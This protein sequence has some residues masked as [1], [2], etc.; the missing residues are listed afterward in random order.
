[1][2]YAAIEE[3]RLSVDPLLCGEEWKMTSCWRE[4]L[5]TKNEMLYAAIKVF[6]LVSTH[7]FVMKSVEKNPDPIGG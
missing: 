5:K 2:P 3:Y 6:S 1:M 7:P 4:L